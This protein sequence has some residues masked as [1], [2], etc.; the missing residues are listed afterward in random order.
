MSSLGENGRCRQP[1]DAVSKHPAPD[2][3]VE[4][5]VGDRTLRVTPDHTMLRAGPDGIEEVPASDLA[6][7]DDLPAYDGGET[8]TMT[9]RG[10]ASTAATDGAAPTDTVEAVEYVESDVDHVYC[11][12]VADTH[13]VAVEGTY[14]GQCDGD[15]DCVM[16]LM[17]GLLNFS[18]SYLPDKRGGQMDAPLVMSSRID[19]CEIDDEAHNMD[20]V[21]PIHVSSTRPPAR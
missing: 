20:I 9:A 1:V 21:A 18:K 3:L 7:G 11:L 19:P 17:D 15:E 4:V 16:L 14:V 8:T 2:H 6:A 5:A 10:E 12:T 13:R